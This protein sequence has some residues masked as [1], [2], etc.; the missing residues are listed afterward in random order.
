[1]PHSV[2]IGL[3]GVGWM[4]DLRTASYKRVGDH[5]PDCDAQPRLVVAADEV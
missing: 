5:F 4:G 2:G 3:L 1:M